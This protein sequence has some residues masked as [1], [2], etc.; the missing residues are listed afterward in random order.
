MQQIQIGAKGRYEMRVNRMVSAA[1]IMDGLVEV[2][3]T[4]F[5][6]MLMEN[7]AVDALKPFLWE[8]EGSVGVHIDVT[9]SAATPMGMR[10][11][12]E[13]E[14]IEVN[15]RQIKL[16][17]VAWDEKGQ[18]GSAIHDRVIINPALFVEKIKKKAE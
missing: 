18:I 3:G 7:A 4:P 10:V 11:W 6:V 17:V 13:A 16:K 5:L 8:E 15:N 14:I 9:H 1:A 12:A 2:F